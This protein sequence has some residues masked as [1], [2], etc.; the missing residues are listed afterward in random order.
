MNLAPLIP[1]I[2]E[3]D[4]LIFLLKPR[5]F[6]VLFRDPARARFSLRKRTAI[7]LPCP[8]PH[9]PPSCSLK[10]ISSITRTRPSHE[11]PF[12]IP[13]HNSLATTRQPQLIEKA[14]QSKTSRTT[15]SNEVGTPDSN[16][17]SNARTRTPGT[18]IQEQNT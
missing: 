11:I 17:D 5:L 1:I 18:R 15:T 13:S 2:K 6:C 16:V 4:F 10:S 9:P 8:L 7:I 12:K 3:P 14:R